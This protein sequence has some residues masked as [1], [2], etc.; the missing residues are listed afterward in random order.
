MLVKNYEYNK[1]HKNI[2]KAPFFKETNFQCETP[3][4]M[5]TTDKKPKMRNGRLSEAHK[6]EC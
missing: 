6:K 4:K 5:S 1:T 2:M 3:H